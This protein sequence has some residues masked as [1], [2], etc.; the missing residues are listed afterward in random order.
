[1]LDVKEKQPLAFESFVE[2]LF[3]IVSNVN[4]STDRTLRGIACQC[5]QELEEIYPGVDRSQ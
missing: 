3:D 4:S 2:L 5:L 1:M